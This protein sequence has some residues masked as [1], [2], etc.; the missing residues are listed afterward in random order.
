MGITFGEFSSTFSLAMIHRKHVKKRMPIVRKRKNHISMSTKKI[1]ATMFATSVPIGIGT[2]I[3]S[4]INALNNVVVM[5]RLQ[6]IGYTEQQ[7]NTLYGTYNMAFTVFSLPITIVSALIVSV[8]PILTYAYAC[9]NIDRVNRS[10]SASLKITIIVGL[11]SSALFLSLSYPIVMLLFFH[12]PQAARVAAMLL[13][14]LAPTAVPM[15]LFM[16]TSTILQAIDQLF[17]PTFSS[18]IGGA[19]CLLCDWVLIGQKSIGIFGTP[20]GLFAC[21]TIGSILNLAAIHKNKRMNFSIKNLF[22]KALPPA[23]VM[24]VTGFI[25]FRLMLPSMGLFKSA[26]FSLLAALI[27]YLLVLLLNHSLEREDF[28]ILPKGKSI[29]RILEKLHLMPPTL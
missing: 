21:Y 6:Y 12:Q 26:A 16:L 23:A 19:A 15:T 7:A 24:G 11:A 4:A 27:N 9:K 10:A 13:T 28:M 8:F 18:V 22:G 1:I 25:L 5:R 14:V 20:I 2:I 17:V 3:I 29:I